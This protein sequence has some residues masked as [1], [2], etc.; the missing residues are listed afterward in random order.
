MSNI[1]PTPPSFA[2]SYWRPWKEGSN[3]FD[4][5]L[6]YTRDVSLAKY[7]ADTV[8]QYIS[9]ASEEQVQAIGELGVNIGMASYEQVQAVEKA[10]FGQVQA[11]GQASY[12]QVQAIGELGD[13]IEYS[14][15]RQV[16]AIGLASY[17][18]E[19]AIS[20]LGDKLVMG[21][22]VLS[23]QLDWVN[24]QL[25]F[26]NKNLATQ[27]EQQ[28]L[29][30]LLLQNISELLR[31]PDS[32]KERQHCIE[33]GLKF[34]V[35]AQ[36]DDDLFADALEELLEAEKLMKQDYFV[37]HR[38]GLIYMYSKKHINPQ[39]A[40]DY[41]AKAAKY[42]SIES[43]PKAARLAN[44]LTLYGDSRVN[45]K[46]VTEINAIESLAADSYEKAAFAAYVLGN[47]ELA[48]AHQNKA[49]KFNNCAENYFFLAKYQTRTK[50]IDLCIQ[51]LNK[52]IEEKPSMF[53]A[54]F[55]DLDLVNE[56]EVLKLIEEK[57]DGINKKIHDLINEW[58]TVHSTSAQEVIQELKNL[59]NKT[60]EIRAEIFNK[61]SIIKEDLEN[62]IKKI[63]NDVSE[64][65]TR[66]QNTILTL[67]DADVLNIILELDNCLDKPFEVVKEVYSR[68]SLL[69]RP[70]I[71][72]CKYAGGVVFYIDE[73]GKHGLVAAPIYQ[74][75]GI[76]W[77]NVPKYSES[78][79]IG[80][81]G[82]EIGDGKANTKRII[83]SLGDGIYAATLCA[84]LVLEGY[85]DWFP[86]KDELCLVWENLYQKGLGS[87]LSKIYWSSSE[88]FIP[89]YAWEQYFS[90]YHLHQDFWSKAWGEKGVVDQESVFCAV[91]AIRAFELDSTR[92]YPL[93]IGQ[94]YA[95]GIVFYID[96]KGK[97]G[98]AA[99]PFD[100]SEGIQWY[101]GN[102]LSIDAAATAVGK[103]YENTKKIIACQGNGNYA[104]KLCADLELEGYNDWFLPSKDELYFMWKNLHTRKLGNFKNTN[105]WSSSEAFS[106]Y[107]AWVQFFT[108]DKI[109]NSAPKFVGTKKA[110]DSDICAYSVIAVRAF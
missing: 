92:I 100:Q 63:K 11:I 40:L 17:N 31:V 13:R 98:L 10:Y 91:R 24:E 73:S 26:V 85:S 53:Y 50:Q 90:P 64:L 29:T 76:R 105:Y 66:F 65:K 101:N 104:A 74:I 94:K 30:N 5:F 25:S 87:F 62:E 67:A 72:G 103:G 18:Q 45:K 56:P 57:N 60:Y 95:G 69:F 88:E 78:I 6:D 102:F 32:E 68:N 37:L 28:N 19:K 48:V 22:Y 21:V 42:A 109:Q 34:F 20:F 96:D 106:P 35:N 99:A 2:F 49:V 86:S 41:F 93:R 1:S 4:S 58:E 46:I 61:F 54:V 38:I 75:D 12:K 47:F 82:T 81:I 110:T 52:C 80:A 43:D 16:Q 44:A 84:D 27:I 59:S 7:Q 51:N 77:E 89:D 33:L 39:T 108:Y 36:K 70:L 14:S 107:N 15:E 83:D 3:Q 55:K 79:F 9:Q 71:I 97:Y 23:S 8:G